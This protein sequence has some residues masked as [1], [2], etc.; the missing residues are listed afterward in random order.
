MEKMEES[1]WKTHICAVDPD[2]AAPKIVPPG[3][4]LTH[5]ELAFEAPRDGY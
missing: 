1:I 3:G 4:G 2:A 5:L